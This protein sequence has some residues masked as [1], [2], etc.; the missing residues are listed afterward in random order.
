MKDELRYKWYPV[1]GLG[2]K[3]KDF[4]IKDTDDKR[5]ISV[6]INFVYFKWILKLRLF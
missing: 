4:T 1:L 2:V 6:T 3:N 5:F